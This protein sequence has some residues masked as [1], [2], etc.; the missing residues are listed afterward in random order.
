MEG[1]P[2]QGAAWKYNALACPLARG[3]L[4]RADDRSNV[5]V[6]SVAATREMMTEDNDGTLPCRDL[7]CRRGFNLIFHNCQDFF[8]AATTRA[9]SAS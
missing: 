6:R 9:F 5:G 7:P 2:F 1:K 3:R 4:L 8:F